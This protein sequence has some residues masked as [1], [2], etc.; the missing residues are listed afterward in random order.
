LPTI[1]ENLAKL[2]G[3]PLHNVFIKTA[4]S[5]SE[6]GTI[7]ERLAEKYFC[8]PMHG[9][10]LCLICSKSFAVLTEYNVDGNYNSK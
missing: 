1:K 7:R 3:K 2:D 6:I 9:K 4:Y 8:V 5:E 10:A